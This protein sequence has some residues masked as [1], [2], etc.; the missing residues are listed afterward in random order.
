MNETEI[1]AH[2]RGKFGR[3]LFFHDV[4]DSTNRLAKSIA[5]GSPEGAIVIADEQT[6][7]Q[8]TGAER[9]W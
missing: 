6:A 4:I 9:S 2:I 7:G 1:R 5:P 3:V 8:G